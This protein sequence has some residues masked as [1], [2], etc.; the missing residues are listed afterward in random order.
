MLQIRLGDGGIANIAK[1]NPVHDAT[2]SFTLVAPK[3]VTVRLCKDHTY[4]SD[5]RLSDCG[6]WRGT[7]GQLKVNKDELKAQGVHD[8][9]SSVIWYV[10]GQRYNDRVYTAGE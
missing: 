10:D 6:A 2:S 5:F 4:D 3:N 1:S 8:N 9:I 7:G